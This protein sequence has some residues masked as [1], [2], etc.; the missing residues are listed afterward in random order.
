KTMVRVPEQPGTEDM[1]R[2]NITPSVLSAGKAFTAKIQGM[3]GEDVYFWI[4]IP[5][6]MMKSEN[7]SIPFSSPEQKELTFDD[8][9]GP[10][11]IGEFT[12]QKEGQ[13]VTIR[14]YIP[15]D[16]DYQGT[17]YYGLAR[18]NKTGTADVLWNTTK[19]TPG[20]YFIRVESFRS[21]SESGETIRKAAASVEVT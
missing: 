6:N 10:Y 21:D 3:P 8:T 19:T 15:I 17:K 4:V 18:L 13:N 7:P 5:E 11:Q 20:E 1:L 2:V 16:P 14:T 9:A 12:P